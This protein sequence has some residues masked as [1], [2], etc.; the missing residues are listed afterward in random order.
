MYD[1]TGDTEYTYDSLGR[2]TSVMTYR[3]P[4]EGEGEFS[5]EQSQGDTVGYTYDERGFITGEMAVESFTSMS[6][7]QK[8]LV[9]I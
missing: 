9:R 5:H 2:I 4:G 3:T 7:K 1:S 6:E 8:A